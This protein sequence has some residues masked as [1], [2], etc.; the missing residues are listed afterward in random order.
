MA[1]GESPKSTA[2]H[3]VTPQIPQLADRVF[4]SRQV[5]GQA[6]RLI[7][8]TSSGRWW[9]T[10]LFGQRRDPNAPIHRRAG[11]RQARWP[12]GST[13]QLEYA[14]ILAARRSHPVGRSAVH[15]R[16]SS[17]LSFEISVTGCF[18]RGIAPAMDEH[19]PL[20]AHHFDPV[21]V[22]AAGQDRNAACVGRLFDSRF[23]RM[24]L[25][26]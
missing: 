19:R 2:I 13:A 20:E 8:P 21:L 7:T 5:R 16:L 11:D 22:D 9:G 17:L 25:S 4:R 1:R 26:S 14:D 12:S 10:N 6:R 24:V 15:P 23:E 18:F 3:P